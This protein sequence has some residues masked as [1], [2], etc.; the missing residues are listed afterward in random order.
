M[1]A[2]QSTSIQIVIFQNAGRA[3]SSGS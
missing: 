3:K 2:F 1:R